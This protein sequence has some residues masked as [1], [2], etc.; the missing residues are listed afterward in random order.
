MTTPRCEP[1][2][3]TT[4]DLYDQWAASRLED[5]LENLADLVGA[6]FTIECRGPKDPDTPPAVNS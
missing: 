1:G 6:F 5:T 2:G 4:P 3:P